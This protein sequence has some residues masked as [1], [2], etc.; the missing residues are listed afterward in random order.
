M[1]LQ[2]TLAAV[3]EALSFEV[4][5]QHFSEPRLIEFNH[6]LAYELGLG[7]EDLCSDE[8][9]LI[10][11]GQKRYDPDC[12]PRAFVYAGHQFGHFNPQLG[13]GRAMLLGEAQVGETLY[14]IQLKGSGRTPFSRRGD[15][16]SALGPVLREMIVSEYM[17]RIGIP[18]TRGLCVVLTG[19]Q[20]YRQ[21]IVPGGVF[22]RVAR[23][24]LRIGSFE[25]FASRSQWEIVEKLMMAAVKRYYPQALL[26]QNI[27]LSFFDLYAKKV[28]DLVASWMSVGFI[29]GV[30]NTDNMAI[31]GETIDFGPCAFLDE[32]H[33]DKVFSSI[34]QQG[35]YRYSHQGQIA[36]WNLSVL[37]QC[38]LPLMAEN[39]EQAVSLL[40][41]KFQ[42]LEKYWQN[43]SHQK[44]LLKFGFEDCAQTHHEADK[45]MIQLFLNHCQQNELDF[46]LSFSQL[47]DYCESGELG[48]LDTCPQFLQMFQK[49]SQTQAKQQQISLMRQANP[50]LIPRNHQIEE[51]IAKANQ[52]DMTHYF[53]V[54]A[55]LKNPYL[56]DEKNAFMQTPPE[57]TERVCQTFC[58]T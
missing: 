19:D 25:F 42:A 13:D 45:E 32:F 7:L 52:G 27:A 58:G 41:E 23:G 55:A 51:A 44:M 30:M 28:L 35:R 36:L 34:D 43:I 40:Q 39:K 47:S 5:A 31:S 53:K 20:V 16:L 21:E 11:S 37:A 10:F 6:D 17:H 8:L 33:H 18:S 54:R 29:H 22:T 9:A 4:S 46:T 48:Q 3:D 14:D 24:H 49:R 2:H 26:E 15:G 38:L 12:P 56:I 50:L 57:K 1:K